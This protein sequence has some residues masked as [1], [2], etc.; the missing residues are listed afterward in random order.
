MVCEWLTENVLVEGSSEVGVDE[1]F[2]PKGLSDKPTHELKELKV[3]SLIAGLRIGLVFPTV[4]RGLEQQ[5]FRVA[6]SSR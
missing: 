4:G 1:L 3:V 5:V 6:Y 2:I